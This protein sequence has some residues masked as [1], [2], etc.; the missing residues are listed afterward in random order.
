MGD[1]LHKKYGLK[2][3]INASGRMSILGVSAPSNAVMEA[4]KMGGQ[5]Y[6]EIDD[7]VHK[8]GHHIAQLLDAE[9]AVVVNSASSG[10]ALSVAALVTEGERRRSEKLH[11]KVNPENE[12]IMFK[13]HNVQYRSEE[14]TSELQSRGHLVCRLL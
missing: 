10:I 13:G 3:V 9:D 14:H 2:R 11:Q 8:A 1:S 4:M 5:N 12:I 6:V 7:L